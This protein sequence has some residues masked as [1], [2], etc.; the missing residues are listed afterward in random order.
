MQSGAWIAVGVGVAWTIFF[1]GLVF[2]MVKTFVKATWV[3]IQEAHPGVEP[4]PDAVSRNFQSFK[5]GV[6]N[7]GLC[8]H[9]AVDDAH[10]HL[11]PAAFLRWFG[12][13]RASVPWDAVTDLGAGIMNSRKV[14]IEGVMVHGPAWCLKL[15]A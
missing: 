13:G 14:R 6:L 5:M 9:V 11:F 1:L 10:L 15:A 7:L 4:A 8:V 12:A 2:F 3:K